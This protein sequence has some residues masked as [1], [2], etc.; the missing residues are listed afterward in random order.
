MPNPSSQQPLVSVIVPIYNAKDHIARCVESIRRQTYRNLQILLLND[1]SQDV[2]L[3]VCRMF[4]QV[5]GRITLINKENSGVSATRNLGMR[6]ARGAYLQ[7]VDADD[8][9]QPYATE[10]LVQRARDSG[11]DMV[12]AH[13]NRVEPPREHERA[14]APRRVEDADPGFDPRTRVQTFGFLME[15]PLTKAEFAYGLM[16]EPASFYYGVMWNKLYRAEIVRAHPD[17]VCSEELDYSEDF[18][19]NLSFIRYAERFYALSTPIYNYVQ[20][21]QSLVHNLNPMKVLTTRW[22]LSAYYKDLYRQLG[23]YEENRIRLNKYFFGV[24][25]T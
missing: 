22:E 10:L 20:N 6:A 5:D 14:R 11:A 17:V 3:E 18:Y 23:L 13:Y 24:A 21:P 8:T 4:A 16:Q 1:G 19:F 9:L 2:S 12:I 15:G 7:F 25:E